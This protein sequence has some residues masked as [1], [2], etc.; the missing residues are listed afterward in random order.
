MGWNGSGIFTRGYSWVNDA[1][2]SIPITASRMDADT[3]DI[4]GN[5]LNNCLTRDGQGGPTA[6]LPMNGFRHTGASNGVNPQDYATMNQISSLASTVSPTFTGTPLLL[7][8]PPVG[9]NSTRIPNTSWVINQIATANYMPI[10]GGH[11]TG[12]VNT[13]NQVESIIVNTSAS[14]QIMATG[15]GGLGGMTVLSPNNPSAASFIS[16]ER[17]GLFACYFG[18]DNDNYLKIGGWSFGSSVYRIQHEGV[19]GLTIQSPNITGSMQYGGATQPHIFVQSSTP[20]AIATG[21]LWFW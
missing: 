19:S 7:N 4:V 5:G 8:A 13:S 20:T 11:F 9:D 17:S 1:A 15:T 3:N 18:L 10:L 2:N 14:G 6:N 12:V 16:F 21:D